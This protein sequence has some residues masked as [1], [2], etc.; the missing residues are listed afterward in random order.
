MRVS[1]FTGGAQIDEMTREGTAQSVAVPCKSIQN[2]GNS[3][4]IEL[5]DKQVPD[6]QKFFVR[7]TLVCT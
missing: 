4:S 7:R 5:D 3:G 6:R 2:G 1:F